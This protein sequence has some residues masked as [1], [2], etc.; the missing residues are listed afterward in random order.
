MIP[1]L[2]N[3]W[4]VFTNNNNTL[5]R[6]AIYIDW[7]EYLNQAFSVVSIDVLFFTVQNIFQYNLLAEQSQR[8]SLYKYYHLTL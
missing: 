2:S 8:A 6:D 5:Y 4:C 1:V 3:L 7:V